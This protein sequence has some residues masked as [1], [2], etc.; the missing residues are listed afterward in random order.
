MAESSSTTTNTNSVA[1]QEPGKDGLTPPLRDA[2]ASLQIEE[3]DERKGLD[4]LLPISETTLRYKMEVQFDTEAG[5]KPFTFVFHP[6][7]PRKLEKLEREARDEN[8]ALDTH[9]FNCHVV[10]EALDAVID[11]DG[12]KVS[13][14]SLDWVANVPPM[15]GFT[16]SAAALAA[17]FKSQGGLLDGMNA[18]VQQMSGYDATRVGVP[19]RALVEAA[20]GL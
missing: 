12:R 15:A 16:T 11:E 10:S 9:K 19:E 8:Q 3:K 5:R 6:L 2:R 17:R 13:T 4:F 18:R 7:D 20:K 1:D 14:R